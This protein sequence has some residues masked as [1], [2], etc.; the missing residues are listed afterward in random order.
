MP[1]QLVERVHYPGVPISQNVLGE[2]SKTFF[3]QKVVQFR[4]FLTIFPKKKFS[5]KK[6]FN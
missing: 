2:G 6:I 1:Q 3:F 5:E 4:G